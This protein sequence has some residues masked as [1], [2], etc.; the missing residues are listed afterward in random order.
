MLFFF[1]MLICASLLAGKFQ[2]AAYSAE[3]QARGFTG[4]YTCYATLLATAT[5]SCPG[6][7]TETIFVYMLNLAVVGATSWANCWASLKAL[8]F[9]CHHRQTDEQLCLPYRQDSSRRP[10]PVAASWATPSILQQPAHEPHPCSAGVV[11]ASLHLF[12]T[13]LRLAFTT[14]CIRGTFATG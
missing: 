5:C 12:H 2:E 1:H 8:P 14:E 10:H 4:A 6:P 3:A 7:T 9:R 11:S 13:P